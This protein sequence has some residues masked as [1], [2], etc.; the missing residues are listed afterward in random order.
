MA[1]EKCVDE[2]KTFKRWELL[3]FGDWFVLDERERRIKFDLGVCV[4][5]TEEQV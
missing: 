5:S 3:G 4:E 2:L 1:L